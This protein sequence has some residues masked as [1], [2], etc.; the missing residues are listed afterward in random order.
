MGREWRYRVRIA[1]CH[2]T[3]Y[4]ITA[5][6]PLGVV[7]FDVSFEGGCN[8]I[9]NRCTLAIESQYGHLALAKRPSGILYTYTLFLDVLDREGGVGLPLSDKYVNIPRTPALKWN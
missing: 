6:I 7:E 4:C 5:N 1:E 2:D 8:I 3:S 9:P